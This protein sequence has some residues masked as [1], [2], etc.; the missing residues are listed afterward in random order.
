LIVG[1]NAY[2]QYPL[3]GCVNDANDWNSTL[4]GKGFTNSVILDSSATKTTIMNGFNWLFFGAKSSDSLVFCYSGHGS[5]VADT[6][7]D[8]TD[9]YDEVLCP[10]DF[11]SGK[12]IS[13]DELRSKFNTLPIGVTFDVFLDSCYSGTGTRIINEKFTPRCIPIKENKGFLRS[14]VIVPSLNH[15]LWSASK[16]NQT[17]VEATIN[18]KIRGLFTYYAA[19][20]IRLYSASYSRSSLITSIQNSVIALNPN[21]NPQLEC[22]NTE[23]LE[24]P[25]T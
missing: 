10:V 24:K 25:F 7:G 14:S 21:Q 8:E 3:Q 15:S 18:G 11:F 4:L 5:R 16:D 12:Y 19:K 23:N 22:N 1:I 17:S 2:P 6:S 9:F 20:A 13:D